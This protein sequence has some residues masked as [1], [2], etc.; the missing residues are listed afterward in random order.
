ML[1][2]AK[3]MTGISRVPTAVAAS[4]PPSTAVPK[5]TREPAPAPGQ[6]PG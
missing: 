3:Y 4:I 5:E 1:C 6:P 2:T